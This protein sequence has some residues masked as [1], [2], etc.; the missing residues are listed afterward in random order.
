MAFSPQADCPHLPLKRPEEFHRP[1]QRQLPR[2]GGQ[3]EE[4]RQE[5]LRLP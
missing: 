5:D 1:L 2:R 3:A 4:G